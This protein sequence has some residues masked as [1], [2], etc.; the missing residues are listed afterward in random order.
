MVEREPRCAPAENG[1]VVVSRLLP[2]TDLLTGIEKICRNNRISCGAVLSVVG[3]LA[4]AT[5]QYVSRDPAEPSG[6]KYSEPKVVSRP[7]EFLS[8]QGLVGTEED[9]SICVHLHGVCIDDSGWVFGG[10]FG[11]E[12]NPVLA[13]VE[14]V[15]QELRGGQLTR[16]YDPETGFSLFQME[17]PA[18]VGGE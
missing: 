12:G 6:V 14:V 4:G 18:G 10:H 8:G 9:G 16:R 15:L 13:T 5:Y 1:R 11:R 3:S 2:G 17:E 7:V